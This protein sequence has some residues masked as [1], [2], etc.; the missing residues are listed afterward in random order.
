MPHTLV[1]ATNNAHKAQ[2]VQQILGPDFEIKTLREIGCFEDIPETENTLEGN[3]L[4]KARFVRDH[5]GLDCFS[6]DS[7]LEVMALGGAP[8]VHSARYAGEGRNS[9]DNIALLLKNLQGLQDRRAQFRAVVALVSDGQEILLEGV[10][11]GKIIDEKRGSG[12]FGYD[13]VFIPDGYDQTFAELG[14]EIKNRIS[15]RGKAI[16]KLIKALQSV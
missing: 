14:D 6:D 4:L 12:G 3:A 2:E 1:F 15:H 8:G 5:F 16:E 13:P 10:C 7:G 11:T 9:E